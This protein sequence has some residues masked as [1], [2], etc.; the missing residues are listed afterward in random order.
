MNSFA[1]MTSDEFGAKYLIKFPEQVTTNCTGSQPST[2]NLPDEVDWSSKG[3][4]T[5]IKNQGQCGSASAFATVDSVASY[6]II[7][8]GKLVMPSI[9]EYVD[10]CLNGSCNGG[11]FGVFGYQCIAKLGGL[12]CD[13]IPNANRTC[14][15]KEFEPCVMIDGGS[16]VMPAGDEK[17][18]A[19]ALLF[20]E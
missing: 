8:T 7:E 4:V 5:P 11:F 19:A 17:A 3:A 20:Y 12:A 10:C 18:L 9:D 14:L 13:Y 16:Q 6:S 2:S 15:S 1:D